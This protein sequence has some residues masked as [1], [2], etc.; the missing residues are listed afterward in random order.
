MHACLSEECEKKKTVNRSTVLFVAHENTHTH[1]HARTYTRVKL[2]QADDCNNREWI[3][4]HC[5]TVLRSTD[6]KSGVKNTVEKQD[7]N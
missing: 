7:V 3:K 5:P 4:M 1:T 6:K 2:V